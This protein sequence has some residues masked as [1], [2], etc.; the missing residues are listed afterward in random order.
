MN[1]NPH[2]IRHSIVWDKSIHQGQFP[3]LSTAETP[4]FIQTKPVSLRRRARKKFQFIPEVSLVFSSRYI[5]HPPRSPVFFKMSNRTFF[6]SRAGN[7]KWIDTLIVDNAPKMP[8]ISR[9]IY[10]ARFWPHRRW[11]TE[12]P[13]SSRRRR[14]RRRRRREGEEEGEEEQEEENDSKIGPAAASFQG[15]LIPPYFAF[16]SLKSS[17]LTN[18]RLIS[19][20][21]NILTITYIL[22]IL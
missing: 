20:N 22:L 18:L 7:G 9:G 8:R 17:H 10:S 6:F 11:D 13:K 2:Q 14:R 12:H 15:G 16:D 3:N 21:L 19:A 5:P 4:L 1:S